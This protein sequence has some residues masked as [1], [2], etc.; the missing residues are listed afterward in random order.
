M[1]G[2]PTTHRTTDA[3]RALRWLAED[4]V[5]RTGQG[6]W[7]DAEPPAGIL[8]SE[9]LCNGL[10][11]MA[12][13]DVGL[14]LADRL[15]VALGL[16][17]LLG[18]HPL[19]TAQ[20]HTAHLGPQGPLPADLLWDGYR[21]RLE[22]GPACEAITCSLWFD[23][24]EYA[25]TAEE[26]F[27]EVL[28][29]DRERLQPGAPEPLLR[30]ARRVLEHSGPVPW[31]AKAPALRAAARVPALHHAVFRAVLRSHHDTYGSIDPAPGLALL[32]GLELPSDTER[33]AALRSELA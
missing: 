11:S 32:D 12:F 6:T 9:D 23:W 13:T 4:G 33:L 16:M 18:W 20:V 27:A 14:D 30:R 2:H 28:G 25:P 22:A 8:T 24:F 1:T 26:A 31:A 21:R 29:N 5:T 17:D 15:R 7:Y 10:G 19:V 3:E